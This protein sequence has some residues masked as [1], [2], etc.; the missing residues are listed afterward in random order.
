M[1][2]NDPKE[3]YIIVWDAKYSSKGKWTDT[4]KGFCSEKWL[5]EEEVAIDNI[6]DVKLKKEI[7]DAFDN[8]N[9]LWNIFK[10]PQ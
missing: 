1:V 10:W 9:I 3:K 4:V 8:G 7:R 6:A 2:H 5:N